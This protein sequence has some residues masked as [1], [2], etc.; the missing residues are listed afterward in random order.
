MTVFDAVLLAIIGVSVFF[1]TVR[2]AIRELATVASLAVA[3]LLAWGGAKPFAAVLGEKSFFAT[4]ALAGLVGV[5]V[6]AGGY[7]LL[8]KAIG[9]LKF[10]ARMKTYDRVGGG[11]FGLLRALALIG[12]GFL[13]YG[14]YLDEGSQPDAVRKAMLLPL[15]SSAAGFFEQFAPSNRD[16]GAGGDAKEADAASEGYAGRD[17]SGLQ[18]IVATV[19]T[20]DDRETSTSGDPIT[21]ILT[22]EATSD[23]QPD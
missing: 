23:G 7:F 1:A 21:D 8:H 2:G 19:T 22:E 20:R 9:R 4:L 14:Y 16:L 17:R 11:A 6:F 5:A 10:S 13:G 3:A 18:E 12:L 15:A